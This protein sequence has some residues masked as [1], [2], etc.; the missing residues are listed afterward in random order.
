MHPC[1]DILQSLRV[2][3]EHLD[4]QHIVRPGVSKGG[5][6]VISIYIDY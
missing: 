6:Q 5:F 3:L 1:H 4:E 2:M